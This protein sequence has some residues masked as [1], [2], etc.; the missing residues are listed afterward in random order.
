L[1]RDAD[2]LFVDKKFAFTDIT[3]NGNNVPTR[4]I[5]LSGGCVG[6]LVHLEKGKWNLAC[7][8]KIKEENEKYLKPELPIVPE[9]RPETSVPKMKVYQASGNFEVKDVARD[10]GNG[11]SLLKK[12]V[13][14]TPIRLFCQLQE[15]VPLVCTEA[16]EDKLMLKAG[17]SRRQFHVFSLETYAGFEL[18]GVR[19]VR[20]RLSHNFNDD[21][22]GV[23]RNRFKT[24]DNRGKPT[25]YFGG[26]LVDYSVGGKYKKRVSMASAFYNPKCI[27]K[28]AKWGKYGI[29]DER[30]D[31]GAWIE[32]PSPKEFSLDIAKFAPKGWDGK[33]WLSLGTCRF[34]AGHHLELEILS[35]NEASAK[36]FIVPVVTKNMRIAPPPLK[37]TPLKSRPKSLVAID[38]EEWKGWAKTDPF[39]LRAA[40]R[41]QAQT[42]A[43]IA[44]DYEYFYMGI[45][46][47]EPNAP[48]LSGQEAWSN[49][50]IE[51]LV[52]RSDGHVYQVI[53][54]PKSETVLL[55]DRKRNEA[56][57]IVVK[58]AVDTGKGWKLFMAVPLDD[59]KPNMQLTPVTLKME[60]A[61]VRKANSEYSTW[62][63][64]DTGFF[65]LGSYG[66]VI[67]DFSWTN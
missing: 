5:L 40:G 61:R 7:K 2:I 30:L 6:T 42:R 64:I 63:P 25:E 46:A 8:V 58:D 67:L 21:T 44:H 24:G 20:L 23:S 41:P 17:P 9:K 31:F 34:L 65:E 1:E 57:G 45:E 53:A 37:S 12:G 15:N 26:I 14:Q 62:T 49:D 38:P 52:D 3:A 56:K 35:F 48:R 19:Q 51:L 18:N 29:A 59:L 36:D 54:A 33:I 47:D 27:I 60:I 4:S 32:Q 66:T 16:D 50:H 55:L 39:W 28:G 11:V 43:Y 10:L 13:S 22:L